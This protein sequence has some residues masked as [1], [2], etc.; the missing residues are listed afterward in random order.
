MGQKSQARFSV[1]G[2]IR[3]EGNRL[4]IKALEKVRVGKVR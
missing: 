2:I 4:K 1:D 3:S